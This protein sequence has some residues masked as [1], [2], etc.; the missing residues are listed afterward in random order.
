MLPSN[1]P[2]EEGGQG[3]REPTCKGSPLM[4]PPKSQWSNP[5]HKEYSEA[6]TMIL[7]A[8]W[9]RENALKVRALQR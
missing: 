4:S 3:R 2:G 5:V 8:W 7:E 1:P 9:V 6:L